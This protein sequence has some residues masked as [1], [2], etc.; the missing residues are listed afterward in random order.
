VRPV[1]FF[2]AIDNCKLRW[3]RHHPNT[4]LLR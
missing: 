2:T 4:G 1:T 3:D